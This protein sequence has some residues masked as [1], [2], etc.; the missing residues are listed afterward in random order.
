VLLIG[1]TEVNVLLWRE[2]VA[3]VGSFSILKGASASV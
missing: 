2:Y 1:G 3:F